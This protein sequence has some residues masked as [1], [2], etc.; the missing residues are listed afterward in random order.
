M[1]KLCLVALALALPLA[2]CSLLR[3][4][5]PYVQTADDA[6]RAICAVHAAKLHGV[7]PKQALEDFCAKREAWEPWIDAALSI[8]DGVPPLS[9]EAK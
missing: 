2:G 6:A 9:C 3:Q 7:P 4:A 5:K 1:I 8:E